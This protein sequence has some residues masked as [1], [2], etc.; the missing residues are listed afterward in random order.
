MFCMLG[1]RWVHAE[2]YDSFLQ[3]RDGVEV[4]LLKTVAENPGKRLVVVGHRAAYHWRKQGLT[5]DVYTFG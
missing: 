1:S 3:T 5:L 4:A 2:F